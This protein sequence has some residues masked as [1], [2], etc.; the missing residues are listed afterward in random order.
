MQ[1][2]PYTQDDF[3]RNPLMF[4]YEITRRA[5]LS[6]SIAGRRPRK[7]RPRTS[8]PGGVSPLI[9]QVA[10]FPRPPIL[11]CT[12]GDPLKRADLFDPSKMPVA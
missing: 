4:Y 5:I 12:G 8:S 1:H 11:V 6:A 3:T 10:S 2:R 7:R 9:D